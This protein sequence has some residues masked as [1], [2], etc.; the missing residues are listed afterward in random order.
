MSHDLQLGP[1]G[2]LRHLLTLDGLDAGQ[3]GDLLERA[4]L[5]LPHAHAGIAL[6]GRHAGRTLCTL[7]FEASTRTRSSFQLAATRLGMD[8]LN[9]DVATSSTNKGESA[10]DTFKTIEAMGVDVFVVR[11]ASEGA[12]AELAAAAGPGTHII[13][14]GDGRA[15]HPTQGLLDMLTLRQHK[16][17]DLSGLKVLIAGDVLHSRVA[18]SDLHALRALGCGEIRVC[19]PA[20]LLPD[21]GVLRGCRVVEGFDDAVAGVDAVIML[22]LQRERM[23]QG[24]VAS[25]EDYFRDYGLDA[26]RLALAAPG[27]VVLHPGPMNRGVEIDGVVAD[28]PQSLVLAQVANGLPV[29]MAVIDALLS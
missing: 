22:R 1:D 9:F 14:A 2:R 20:N 19:G 3:A 17:A 27:A 23:A 4:E 25:L 8:V 29:R 28:G 11:H 26:A 13:N 10:L 21:A 12:V 18:R 24:L 16:G 5:M 7:F 15:S 6:R